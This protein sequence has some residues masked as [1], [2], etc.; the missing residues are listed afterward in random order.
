LKPR[1][2]GCRTS[3][4]L[5]STSSSVPREVIQFSEIGIGELRGSVADLMASLHAVI[6]QTVDVGVGAF[7]A[8]DL[9]ERFCHL[10]A[11]ARCWLD[12]NCASR[13]S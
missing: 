13:G 3:L 8:F 11:A 6:K 2:P 10:M 1:Q 5:R 4:R 7:M 9:V 12:V